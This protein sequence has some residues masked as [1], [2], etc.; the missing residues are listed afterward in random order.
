VAEYIYDIVDPVELTGYVRT[1]TEDA[2]P[3]ADLLPILPTTDI[4]YELTQLDHRGGPVARYRGWDVPAQLGRRPGVSTIT[5]EIPPLSLA[6]DL[7]EKEINQVNALRTGLGDRYDQRVVDKILDD[8]VNAALGVMNRLSW[9]CAELLTTAQVT[10]TDATP[11]VSAGNAVKAKF[12]TPP[13][14]LAVAPLGALWS[15]HSTSVPL[16]DLLAWETAFADNNGGLPPDAWIMSKKTRSHLAQNTQVRAQML[17]APA[18]YVATPNDL[19]AV[20]DQYGIS[21]R[22]VVSDIR[23]PLMTDDTASGRAIPENYVIAVRSAALGNTLMAP[24]SNATTL[25]AGAPAR[26]VLASQP[27]ITAFQVADVNPAKI[28]TVA[29]AVALPVLRDPNALFV[30]IPHA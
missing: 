30:A 27:G 7:R 1:A 14:Q 20:M 24:S 29:D 17:S 21:G 23:L 4:E 18:G 2:F 13:A 8:A 19:S 10:L 22:L 12:A 15:N 11:G 6:Y 26:S 9:A 3:F 16:D 25:A 5:G 28:T